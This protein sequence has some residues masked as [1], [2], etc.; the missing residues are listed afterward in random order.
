MSRVIAVVACGFSLAACST[1]LPSLSLLKPSPET[2]RIE[3]EPPGADAKTSLGQSCRTP[4]EL[5]VQGGGEFA[6]TLALHGYQ[7]QTV[8][9]QPDA[10]EPARVTPNP[11][12][13]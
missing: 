10:A 9:V 1:S 2:L 8:M 11:I 6:V 5:A 3:S 7:A 4:C 13:V 12:Y